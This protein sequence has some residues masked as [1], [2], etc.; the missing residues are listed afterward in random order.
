MQGRVEVKVSYGARVGCSLAIGI[1]V[2]LFGLVGIIS[3]YVGSSESSATTTPA[4]TTT[5]RCGTGTSGRSLAS[6]PITCTDHQSLSQ[7]YFWTATEAGTYTFAGRDTAV[8]QCIGVEVKETKNNQVSYRSLAYE[9]TKSGGGAQATLAIQPGDYAIHVSDFFSKP[10]TDKHP[11]TFSI[12]KVGAPAAA[13]KESSRPFPAPILVFFALGAIFLFIPLLLGGEKKRIPRYIDPM[14]V[15]MRN[16]V[17]LPWQQYRGIRVLEERR[18]NSPHSYEVGVELMFAGGTALI[19]YR[20]LTNPAEV[21]WITDS[22]KQG[23][24]PF[25]G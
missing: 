13:A 16:G 25:A 15:T 5:A 2:T 6:G 4:K 12:T 18:A 17:V 7:S 19:K 24:N 8:A 1:V 20:P 9:C 22:L 14:G 23:R 3:Y 21:M 11:Y 10:A